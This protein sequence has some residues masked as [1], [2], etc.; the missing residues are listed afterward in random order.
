MPRIKDAVD[1]TS[2]KVDT[3][4][5]KVSET[6]VTLGELKVLIGDGNPANTDDA[7]AALEAISAKVDEALA[8]LTTAEDA[9]DPTPDA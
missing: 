6:V 1:A 9:A 3:L 2:A 7:V 4:L 5:T 8:N